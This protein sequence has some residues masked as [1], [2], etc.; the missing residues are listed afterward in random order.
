MSGT[1]H[2]KMYNIASTALLIPKILAVVQCLCLL[3]NPVMSLLMLMLVV[4]MSHSPP[5]VVGTL[6]KKSKLFF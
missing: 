5:S 4:F 1:K 2:F 3:S 6:L